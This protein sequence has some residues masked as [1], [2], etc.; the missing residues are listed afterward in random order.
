MSNE[1][2]GKTAARAT[3]AKAMTKY[4]VLESV[5]GGLHWKPLG[6]YEA[7]SQDLAKR[8]AAAIAI[9][10]RG[11]KEG[12]SLTLVAIPE[13]SWKPLTARIEIPKARLVMGG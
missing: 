7:A 1:T 11:M 3:A 4:M 8:T 2:N 6:M 5:E 9:D 10:E 13:S 12:E